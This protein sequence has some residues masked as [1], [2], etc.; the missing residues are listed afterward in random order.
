MSTAA[1]LARGMMDGQLHHEAQGMERFFRGTIGR[2]LACAFFSSIPAGCFLTSETPHGN[3][4]ALS[5]TDQAVLAQVRDLLANASETTKDLAR[6]V[7]FL[8]AADQPDSATSSF[9]ETPEYTSLFSASDT[10]P[11]TW[12]SDSPNRFS[13]EPW[14]ESVYHFKRQNLDF[15]LRVEGRVKSPTDPKL[16]AIVMV[17]DLTTKTLGRQS[18]SLM[19]GSRK[20]AGEALCSLTVRIDHKAIAHIFASLLG[21][22]QRWADTVGFLVLDIGDKSTSATIQNLGIATSRFKLSLDRIQYERI[23]SA[24][25]IDASG[26]IAHGDLT[27]QYSVHGNLRAPESLTISMTEGTPQ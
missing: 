17:A 11:L 24:S 21:S 16:D 14:N 18:I 2:L 12:L 8:S 25:N 23:G 7:M 5:A 6:F 3:A 15:R 10:E 19:A 13:Y 9:T 4:P 22:E 27:R 20:C 26:T 1:F